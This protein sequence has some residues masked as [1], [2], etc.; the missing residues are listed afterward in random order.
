MP[1]GIHMQQQQRQQQAAVAA[2]ARMPGNVQSLASLPVG[3]AGPQN[4]LKLPE[5]LQH[6]SPEEL[7]MFK[8][9]MGQATSSGQVPSP[10][11]Q[12][13][14]AAI[15]P[16]PSASPHQMG[17]NAS[18][19][20]ALL[21]GQGEQVQANIQPPPSVSPASAAGVPSVNSPRSMELGASPPLP[22]QT[23]PATPYRLRHPPKG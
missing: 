6:L 3:M 2:A 13:M 18:A 12:M 9:S 1:R 14:A 16:Q 7:M 23:P 11:Q 22:S 5:V 15:R 21:P 19:M 20:K 10:Q 8:R 17:H 4:R